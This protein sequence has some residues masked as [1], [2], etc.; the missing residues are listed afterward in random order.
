MGALAPGT[1]AARPRRVRRGEASV[2]VHGAR[3]MPWCARSPAAGV[4]LAGLT[5]RCLPGG[6]QTASVGCSLALAREIPG[7]D[8]TF[9][10]SAPPLSTPR[11][12]PLPQEHCRPHLPRRP[13]VLESS[14]CCASPPLSSPA[15]RRPRPF[16]Q[17]IRS[18]RHWSRR[19]PRQHQRCS[20]TPH[21]TAAPS[22]IPLLLC[23]AVLCLL[24]L[25]LPPRPGISSCTASDVAVPAF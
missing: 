12:S 18:P 19:L 10:T 4:A 24:P 25:L 22:L 5:F 17:P 16:S 15:R 14:S 7:P 2:P 21:R 8:L 9:I 20:S 1:H 11:S 6:E 13:R 23:S 3:S